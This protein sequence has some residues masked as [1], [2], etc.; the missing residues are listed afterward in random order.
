MQKSRIIGS[1]ICV[2]LA[3]SACASPLRA[4]N[5]EDTTARHMVGE[6][7]LAAQFVSAAEKNGM[8]ADAINAILKD[9]AG[10]SAIEE[11]WITDSS[12]QA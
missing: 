2:Y 9:I 5:C 11:F 3:L 8:S 7:M 1:I 12:G 10:K 4:A 6:A